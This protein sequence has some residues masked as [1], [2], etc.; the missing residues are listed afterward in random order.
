[1][2][3]NQTVRQLSSSTASDPVTPNDKENPIVKSL[4]IPQIDGEKAIQIFDLGKNSQYR[5]MA[6]NRYTEKWKLLKNQTKRYKKGSG[7]W[8]HIGP[9]TKDIFLAFMMML[10][11]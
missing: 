5:R 4:Q 11:E 1:M 7:K 2:T 10:D 6:V 8:H 9:L 3:S